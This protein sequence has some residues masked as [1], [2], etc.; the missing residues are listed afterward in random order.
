MTAI[1]VVF[2]SNVYVA[3]A[4]NPGKYADYWLE[5]A[6]EGTQLSLFVSPEILSEIKRKLRG[7]KLNVLSTQVTEFIGNIEHITTVVRPVQ[8]LAVVKQDPDDN[9]V[10]ECAVAADAALI[11]SM[12]KHLLKLKEFR[13]IGIT[14]PSSLKY[15]LQ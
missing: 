8:K 14:H 11:I 6:A 12:D 13:G 10:L 2:D 3:A 4:L 15:I 7:S 5:E 9:K 1:R